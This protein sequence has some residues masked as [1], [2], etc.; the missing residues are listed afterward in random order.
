MEY[1]ITRKG[2]ILDLYA[3]FESAKCGKGR[4]TYVMFFEKHLKRNIESLADELLNHTYKPEPSSCFIVEHPKKREVFAAQFRDR[5]VHHLYYNYTHTM[6]EHTF[7]HDT[8]SC[9]PQRGTHY[10]IERLR[11]HIEKESRNWQKDCYIMKIDIRGYFMHINRKK[12]LDISLASLDKMSKRHISKDGSLTFGDT[13][14]MELVKWLTET[15]IMLD[16]KTHCN[17]IGKRSDWVGLDRNKSL[18]FTKKGRGLPIGNLTSQLFS[19]VYMNVFDQYMKR[20]MKSRHYGRYVDD[21]YVVSCDKQWLTSLVPCIEKFL[22]EELD[23]ELHKGKLIIAKASQGVEFLGGFVKQYRT[24][25]SNSSLDRTLRRLNE[26]KVTDK[27]KAWRCINSFLGM[28]S[29][30][31]SFNIRANLFLNSEFLSVSSFNSDMTK[32]NKAI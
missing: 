27:E 23:L 9:I 24:Y 2:L 6:F 3:A 25:V 17:I 22:C 11:K 30:F 8:Y 28:M 16:P 20:V 29:H 14:D 4:K 18:F 19:N 7:I 13:I 21:A 31:D 12:L 26:F 10:G 15:I 1:K 5:V 32:F